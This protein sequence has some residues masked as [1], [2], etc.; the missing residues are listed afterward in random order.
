[1]LLR[2]NPGVAAQTLRPLQAKVRRGQQ[3]AS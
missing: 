3:T 1:M 2:V